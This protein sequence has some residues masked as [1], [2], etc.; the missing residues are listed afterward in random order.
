[1][2]SQFQV[3]F[4]PLFEGIEAMETPHHTE[5]VQ[6]AEHLTQRSAHAVA[7]GTEAPYLKALGMDTII[8]GPGNIAQ[9][10]QPNEFIALNQLQPMINILN[11]LI[12]HFC[13]ST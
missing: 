4:V 11:Q 3:E 13:L 1:M 2:A 12:K 9:A 10:H 5:I 6:V 8:L 7:F